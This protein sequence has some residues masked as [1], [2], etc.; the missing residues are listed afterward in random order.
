MYT[1]YT[2]PYGERWCRCI[3]RLGKF[4]GLQ[5]YNSTNCLKLIKWLEI[6]IQG[7]VGECGRV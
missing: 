2:R 3:Y 4:K 5:I 6:Y 7:K 1:V